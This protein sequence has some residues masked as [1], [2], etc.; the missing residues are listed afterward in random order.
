MNMAPGVVLSALDSRNESQSS[1]PESQGKLPNKTTAFGDHFPGIV[2]LDPDLLHALRQAS[3]AANA[4]GVDVFVNSGWRSK[5]YQA[6]L[7]REA[8]A[9]YGSEEEASRWVATPEVSSHVSG[10]AVDLGGVD[11]TAWFSQ[12]GASYGLCQTYENE[13][14]H[15]ELRPEA[16]TEGCP[17]MSTDATMH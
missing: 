4:E 1:D 17:A 8:A 6:Q 13:P 11:A 12:F 10:R 5:E 7:Y 15:Y 3:T 2:N 9:K 16:A 14:W